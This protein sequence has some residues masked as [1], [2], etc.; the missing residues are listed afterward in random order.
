MG[1]ADRRN[2]SRLIYN[3]FRLGKAVSSLP[4]DERLFVSEF[5]CNTDSSPFL[6][7]F[8]PE[9]AERIT[10][11]LDEKIKQVSETVSSFN[12]SDVFPFTRHLSKDIEVH[13][14]LQSFFIQP[15]LFIRLHPGKGQLIKER[16]RNAEINYQ[17][18]SPN[19]LALP[20]GT[21]LDQLFQDE[22]TPFEVQDISSQETGKLF[23]PEQGDYWWDCCAASGGKSLLLFQQE[24]SVR[25]LASDLREN[26]LDNLDKRFRNAGLTR[27]QKKVL[28]LTKSAAPFLHDYH[29][30]GILLDAPCSGSGTWGRTPELISQFKPSRIDVFQRLQRSIASNVAPY[31]KE[32]KPL[33]YMTCS[34]FREENEE[35]VEF[36]ARELGFT[37]ESQN[38][39]KG[40]N[41]RADTMF[42][43]RLIKNGP[44]QH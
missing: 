13:Q 22:M 1:S 40:Y 24:T 26:I 2:A 6:A 18:L 23:K 42:A 25:I 44:V 3:Y 34:V 41:R 16:L 32:G 4:P 27:F 8:K 36:I 39:I 21:K 12:L 9:L 5:L 7:Y 37:I 29:F 10:L 31:L 33:I 38:V 28:D 15:D 14:F 30:D 20:N 35:N 11:P 43:A 19:A 17:E